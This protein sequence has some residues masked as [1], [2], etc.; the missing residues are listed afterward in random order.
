MALRSPRPR[1]HQLH[2]FRPRPQQ[3]RWVE[4]PLQIR[5]KALPLLASLLRATLAI[6][7]ASDER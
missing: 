5:R 3:P 6:K 7:E 4:L 1:A 2:L